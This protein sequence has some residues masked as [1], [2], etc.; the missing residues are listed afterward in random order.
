MQYSAADEAAKSQNA[1]HGNTGMHLAELISRRYTVTYIAL[2]EA[3]AS[4][5]QQLL[6]SIITFIR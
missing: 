3:R 5:H 1:E 2:Y 4:N 6:L